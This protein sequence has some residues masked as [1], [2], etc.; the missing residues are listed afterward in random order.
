MTAFFCATKESAAAGICQWPRG[1]VIT[2]KVLD[3]IAKFPKRDYQEICRM[4][5]AQWEAICGVRFELTTKGNANINITTRRIDGPGGILAEAQLPCG[6]PG[7]NT[8]LGLWVD[9]GDNWA[10]ADN[11][12]RGAIDILRVIMHEGGHNIGLGHASGRGT[13]L[14]DQTISKI[15]GPQ[16]GWDIPQAVMR[17]GD[18]S[19]TPPPPGS[20][21]G[22]TIFIPGGTVR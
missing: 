15:R 5:F 6:N 4:A 12:P 22:I 14:M 9:T 2:W 16:S 18:V 17:Y 11:P 21:E 7:P 13:N 3:A 8:Q 20:P 19:Q 1:H 10:Y